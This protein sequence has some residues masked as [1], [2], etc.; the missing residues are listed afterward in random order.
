MIKRKIDSKELLKLFE[1]AED[2]ANIGYWEWD[3]STGEVLWSPRK[4]EIYGED[5]ADYE[6]SFEKFLNVIDE[7]TKSKV[8]REIESVLSNRKEYYNLQHEIRLKSGKIAWVHEKGFV[9]RDSEGNPLKMVGIVYDITDRMVILNEL[10]SAREQSDY[11]KTHDQLTSLQ[12][13][14]SLLSDI[15][16]R[17]GSKKE[18]ALI[19]LDI[20]NF[21]TI[22]NT[23]GHLFGD[24]VI[25]TVAERLRKI[26]FPSEIYR[27][28]GDEF[29]ILHDG[30]E[31][32]VKR[33]V[34]KIDSFFEKNISIMGRSLLLT[35]SMGVCT[36]PKRASGA[37]DLVK[38]AN[39]A[40]SLAKSGG[41]SRVLF[42]EEHMGDHIARKRSVLDALSGA[43]NE[44]RFIVHYQPKVDCREGK[45]LG[46]E[47]LVRWKNEEG[48]LVS[49]ALFLPIAREYGMMNRI[50]YIVLKKA[51]KQLEEWHSEGFKVSLSV[52][53]NIGDFED[54]KIPELVKSSPLLSY[55]TVEITESELMACTRKELDFIEDLKRLGLKISL[56][57]FGTG[58]SS[59][60]YIHMLPI[61]EIK[62]DR[63]F[64]ENIPGNSKDE[65]LVTIIKS[66]VDTFRLG[67]VVEG[68]ERL[69]QKEFFENLGLNTI[70][71]YFYG[72]PMDAEDATKMLKNP[73]E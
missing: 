13:K 59:L 46:F 63:A 35:M 16:R 12:N 57:D 8:L 44:E 48:S 60:R 71:G 17:V 20:D 1:I 3:I 68:V 51:L 66:I 4:I 32:E 31:E 47:A 67:C 62:I 39:S 54:E 61:D 23:F 30:D 69:E 19:F 52:N 18:F 73:A 70:Q 11:L 42:Y 29:V 28:G 37:R 38:N 55:V 56:D 6:P 2:V 53:F 5:S 15:E 21:K 64:V 50:D 34:G 36:F 26:A 22:N 65:A 7:D 40:L 10:R 25:R 24:I 14:E 49:P 43:V 41:K 45:V 72:K 27:Y 9:V 58:Y 33:L